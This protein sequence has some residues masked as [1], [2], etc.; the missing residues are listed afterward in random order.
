MD[1]KVEKLIAL[2][3]TKK[4]VD[5]D[6]DNLIREVR[7]YCEKYPKDIHKLVKLFEMED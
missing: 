7:D 5:E 1:D 3:R 6:T 4:I 2:I